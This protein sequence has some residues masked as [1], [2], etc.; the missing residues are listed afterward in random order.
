MFLRFLAGPFF[1]VFAALEFASHLTVHE[2]THL[3]RYL[4]TYPSP[5]DYRWS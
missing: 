4:S 1:V 2:A 5:L 3:L